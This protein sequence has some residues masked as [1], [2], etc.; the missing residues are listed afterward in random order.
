MRLLAP[1]LAAALLALPAC[2]PAG[3]D[4]PPGGTA[5]VVLQGESAFTGPINTV[6]NGRALF[7]ATQWDGVPRLTIQLQGAPGTDLVE[8][9]SLAAFSGAIPAP[10]T[11]PVTAGFAEGV[12]HADLTRG[13]D[14]PAFFESYE[15]E[16]GSVTI[17]AS[18]PQR[19]VGEVDLVLRT[20]S[21]TVTA[22]GSFSAIPGR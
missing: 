6:L 14:S 4:D 13:S 12:L 15:A 10:G 8:I 19:I 18:S 1:L 11:Y 2:D 16:S 20:S 5:A 7:A 21:Y 3:P 9:L 22:V 17:T